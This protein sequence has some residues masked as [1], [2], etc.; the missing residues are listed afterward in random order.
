MSNTIQVTF[1]PKLQ[2]HCITKVAS[3][4][5]I[6]TIES[7]GNQGGDYQHYLKIS[8]P[9]TSP[10]KL[11]HIYSIWLKNNGDPKAEAKLYTLI[12][13]DPALFGSF[14]QV[15]REQLMAVL[16][17]AYRPNFRTAVRQQKDG[18]GVYVYNV[19]LVFRK[20]AEAEKLFAQMLGLPIANRINPSNYAPNNHISL[21]FTVDILSRQL[22]Q[23]KT[24][25]LAEQ[26]SGYGIQNPAKIPSR[27]STNADL[28]K[29]FQKL[30]R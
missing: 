25:Y 21:D 28:Q 6:L 7:I 5:A 16:K 26:Y 29:A 11:G 2:I 17:Q 30:S 15:Q 13:N 9:G 18:R 19:D 8:Q 22:K 3:G 23:T 14:S 12:L 24:Q 1:V 10:D 4:Q 20:Y 27:I